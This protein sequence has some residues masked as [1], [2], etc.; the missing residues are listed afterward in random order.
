VP[1]EQRFTREERIR[2]QRD[3]DIVYREG[4]T[5]RLP[6]MVL[7]V[8]PNGLAHSRLGLSVSRRVGNAVVRNRVKRLLREAWRLNKTLAAPP[9]DIVAIP[10]PGADRWRFQEVQALLQRGLQSAGKAAGGG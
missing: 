8:R 7:R 3:F 1:G 5:V 6:G 9:S 10:H 2:R 4:R